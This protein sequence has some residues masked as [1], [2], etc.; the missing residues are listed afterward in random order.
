MK[1]YKLALIPGDGT[2]PEV[3]REGM[4]VLE[5]ASKKFGFKFEA[6]NFDFGGERYLRTGEVL[7][8]SAIE[9]FKKFTV[10][11][12]KA[13]HIQHFLEFFDCKPIHQNALLDHRTPSV[14]VNDAKRS[15]KDTLRNLK[16]KRDEKNFITFIGQ[17]LSDYQYGQQFKRV[18]NNFLNKSG[19]KTLK[20]KE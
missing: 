9:D 16:E 15:R 3:I 10:N 8:E 2:G 5:A 18:Y 6:V 4:K 20:V 19:R 1:N 12:N 7:P 13:S 11:S 17:L 14:A